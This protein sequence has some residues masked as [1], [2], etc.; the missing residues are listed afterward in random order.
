VRE[1]TLY[2]I[3]AMNGSVPFSEIEGVFNDFAL[4]FRPKI[5]ARAARP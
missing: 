1:Q 3:S 5:P 2:R 4:S